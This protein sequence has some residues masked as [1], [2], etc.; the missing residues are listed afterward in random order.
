MA[1]F[2]YIMLHIVP[3]PFFSEDMATFDNYL[4]PNII[5]LEKK[6]RLRKELKFGRYKKFVKSLDHGYRPEKDPH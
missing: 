3:N 5:F 2:N 4:F 6:F 1:K